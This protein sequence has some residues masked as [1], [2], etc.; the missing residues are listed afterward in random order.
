MEALHR[1]DSSLVGYLPTYVR[2]S[3]KSSGRA[4]TS[5]LS[6]CYRL[7][8]YFPNPLPFD[9]GRP[10][11]DPLDSKSHFPQHGIPDCRA[12]GRKPTGHNGSHRHDGSGFLPRWTSSYRH[13][14]STPYRSPPPTRRFRPDGGTSAGCCRDAR[15]HCTSR[16]PSGTGDVRR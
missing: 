6:H 10:A 9:Q 3:K 14:L 7:A 11:F 1:P 5:Y 4:T 13:R 2:Y 12:P 16:W 15:S 8:E